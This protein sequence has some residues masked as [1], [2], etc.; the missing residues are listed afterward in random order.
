MDFTFIPMKTVDRQR[1][2]EVEIK[3][4]EWIEKIENNNSTHKQK[5]T[6]TFTRFIQRISNNSRILLHRFKC[7]THFL[8]IQW[9]VIIR[10]IACWIVERCILFYVENILTQ[11][12]VYFHY[13]FSLCFQ[14]YGSVLCAFCFWVFSFLYDLSIFQPQKQVK[15]LQNKVFHLNCFLFASCCCCFCCYVTCFFFDRCCCCSVRIYMTFNLKLV[16]NLNCWP[17]ITL[18]C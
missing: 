3:I 6:H 13:G 9:I 11:S 15:L 8:Q 17:S 16:T 12:H 14:W 2:I 1:N 18:L 7:S 4:S 10:Y 5:E